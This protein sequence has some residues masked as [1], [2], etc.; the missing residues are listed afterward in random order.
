MTKK[1]DKQKKKTL[2]PSLIIHSTVS[3]S[4]ITLPNFCYQIVLEHAMLN[5]QNGTY[6]KGPVES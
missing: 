2:F 1:Q 5:L 6:S 4:V 3:L